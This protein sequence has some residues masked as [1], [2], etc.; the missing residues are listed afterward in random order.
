MEKTISRYSLDKVFITDGLLKIISEG[1]NTYLTYTDS[2]ISESV[3]YSHHPM[4]ALDELRNL[5]ENKHN[6][7]LNCNGCRVDT[8]H[9]YS[10]GY[11]TYIIQYGKQASESV[12]IFDPTKEISKLG[13]LKEHKV[14][15]K[16]WLDSLGK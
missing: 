13:T 10:G 14:A 3:S 11:G 4:G 16:T 8:S 9:K 15:Y 7:I 6:S 12:C 5:L 2:G 1:Q